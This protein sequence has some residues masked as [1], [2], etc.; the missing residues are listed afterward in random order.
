MLEIGTDRH[1]IP[2]DSY[3]SVRM[4]PN[5]HPAEFASWHLRYLTLNLDGPSRI[6]LVKSQKGGDLRILK[7]LWRGC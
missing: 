5:D 4:S 1:Q 3:V 6:G 7:H 2:E